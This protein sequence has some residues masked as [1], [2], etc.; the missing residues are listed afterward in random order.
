MG[1]GP[2]AL[3]ASAIICSCYNV[4]KGKLCTAIDAGCTTMDGLK[5]ETQ[6]ATGCGGC[7][8]LLKSVLNSELA[9][10]GVAVNTDLCEHF[11]YT[12]QELHTLVRVEQIK[13]FRDLLTK[14]GKGLGCEICKPTVGSI[15]ASQWNE[16]ILEKNH[17]GLQDK[18]GRAHV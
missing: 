17:L 7:S 9:K 10:Q 6:A 13:T 8:A 16:H 12:R 3:P 15:L 14:H 18:I 11:A 1:L 4:S 2:D 5:K